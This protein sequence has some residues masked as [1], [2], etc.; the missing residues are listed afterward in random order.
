MKLTNENERLFTRVR[1]LCP[2]L[3]DEDIVSVWEYNLDRTAPDGFADGLVI[4][5]EA[6]VSVFENGERLLEVPLS[7][8]SEFRFSMGV[9]CVFAEYN[10]EGGANDT[11][12]PCGL[13]PKEPDRGGREGCQ[14]LFALWQTCL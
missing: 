4:V 3:S 13:Y 11:A 1:A 10:L 2:G 6:T 9:G 12:F 7:E 14:P 8:I 5:T